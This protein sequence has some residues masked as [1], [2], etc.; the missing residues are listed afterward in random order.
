MRVFNVIK[1]TKCTGKH[2]APVEHT[3]TKAN[4]ARFA[5]TH[6]LP[7]PFRLQI[8]PTT[9]NRHTRT[10]TKHH[11]PVVPDRRW[12]KFSIYS[13]VQ[14]TRAKPK[15]A[16]ADADADA[17]AARCSG[18]YGKDGQVRL[19]P[20][21][22]NGFGKVMADGAPVWSRITQNRLHPH[23]RWS[24]RTM[25]RRCTMQQTVHIWLE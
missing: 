8:Y 19:L 23:I 14:H 22:K 13:V 18:A 25:R 9:P 11:I 20:G 7:Q 15:G 24:R 1:Y 6:T 17:V 10:Y 12:P 21:G 2:S 3:K 5:H 16:Y 4:T